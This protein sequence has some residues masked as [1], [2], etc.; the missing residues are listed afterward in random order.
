MW[1]KRFAKECKREQKLHRKSWAKK[2]TRQRGL[3]RSRAER[4]MPE[5]LGPRSQ[6]AR[7]EGHVIGCINELEDMDT[8]TAPLHRIPLC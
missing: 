8:G 6:S 3:S 5:G 7:G 2:G 4:M 1:D